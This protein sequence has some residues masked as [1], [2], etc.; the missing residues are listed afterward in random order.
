MVC[1]V[2]DLPPDCAEHPDIVYRFIV[3]SLAQCQNTDINQIYSSQSI[4]TNIHVMSTQLMNSSFV[5]KPAKFSHVIGWN[6][7]GAF[8]K[9]NFTSDIYELRR[10]P[11]LEIVNNFY[12][13][14][15][16]ALWSL[17]NYLELD[18]ICNYCHLS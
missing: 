1:K 10:S 2:E 17:K 3:L 7:S 15:L 14:F 5:V 16:G 6:W 13:L 18:A 11:I 9:C 8:T 4:L 12:V